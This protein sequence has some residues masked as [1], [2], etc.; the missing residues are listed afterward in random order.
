[1]HGV[2]RILEAADWR[3]GAGDRGL[4]AGV[5]KPELE[6]DGLSEGGSLRKIGTEG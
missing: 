5:Q 4:E 6:G 1:M 2:G 3:L